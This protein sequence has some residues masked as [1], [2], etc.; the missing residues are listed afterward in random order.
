MRRSIKAAFSAFVI[1]VKAN[2]V[3]M[4]TMFFKN[5]IGFFIGTYEFLFI[6]LVAFIIALIDE[7]KGFT[8][9]YIDVIIEEIED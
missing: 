2:I 4:E 1:V 5:G 8:D 3:F 9:E 6:V 7:L